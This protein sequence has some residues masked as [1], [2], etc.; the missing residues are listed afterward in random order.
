MLESWFEWGGE[1][2]DHRTS[3]VSSIEITKCESVKFF[4]VSPLSAKLSLIPQ[5]KLLL[6]GVEMGNKW[7]IQFL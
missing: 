3:M 1:G 6:C 4:S 5:M 2:G 7:S